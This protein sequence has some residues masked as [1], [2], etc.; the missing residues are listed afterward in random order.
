MKTLIIAINSKYI[1]T[2]L[3][4][5][6]LKSCCGNDTGEV[7]VCEFTINDNPEGIL[8]K[9]YE[10]KAD[11]IAFSCYIW[12]ISLV[13]KLIQ[14]LKK[15][16]PGAKI[17]LGG[18]EVSFDAES[19]MQENL[20]IDYVI[21]GE[22]ELSFK[23]LLEYF[24]NRNLS[25]ND[26]GGLAYRHG[27]EVILNEKTMPIRD[28]DIIP[29]PYCDDMINGIGNRIVYFEASRGCP[30]S[31]SYCLSSTDNGVRYFSMDRVKSELDRLIS[32]GVKQVK[33]V[34]RTFNS[35]KTRAKEI[36]EYIILRAL[37]VDEGIKTN[38][39]FE[40][41]ADLFDD[42]IIRVLSKAPVGLIQLEIGVQTTNGSTLELVD[43]K[44][45]LSK[46]F[47]NI[48]EINRHGNIHLHL[49]L[50]AGLP[51]EDY[52]SFKNSFN[53]VYD[54]KPHQLQLGFLKMLKG[55]KMRREAELHGYNYREYPPYE[56]LFNKYISYIEISNL[57]KV[58]DLVERYFNS[59][60]FN[61]SVNY[62]IKKIDASAFNFYSS[63]SAFYDGT[64]YSGRSLSSRELY[65]VLV[66]YT[67]KN[68][69][70]GEIEVISDL[71]KLDYLSSDNS[72]NLPTGVERII[73]Q[74]FKERC[75]DFLK[76]EANIE[77]YI[78]EFKGSTAKQVFKHVHFEIFTHDVTGVL[79]QGQIKRK[80]T[81]IL[82]DYSGKNPVTDLFGF[83]RVDI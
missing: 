76:S 8:A 11:V 52:E 63:L 16:S 58:E 72:N 61:T 43:R 21:T 66:N 42:E 62:I 46:V 10:E 79:S 71:L 81:I 20:L 75:F 53:Q 14:N 74:G 17:I 68:F 45:D 34:D 2:S 60:R 39:H 12:N 47:S 32:M 27:K 65:T 6:Y 1:H 82:F 48:K 44:T 23:G 3:A 28:L 19:M 26:I 33:F 54:L 51:G 29:S 15:V 37:Q 9:I 31:C 35:S 59:G 57:K 38:F 64:G 49:D 77:K 5:W 24:N 50:I 78:S 30:F 67:H 56:V 40:A 83:Q 73:E 7:K 36:F 55:S 4:V 22:G 70:E 18:P 41:A 80:R 69:K 25:I 13:L